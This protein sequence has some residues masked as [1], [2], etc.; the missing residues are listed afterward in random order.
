MATICTTC[1]VPHA[2]CNTCATNVFQLLAHKFNVGACSRKSALRNFTY[3]DDPPPLVTALGDT[4][5]NLWGKGCSRANVGVA[6][7]RACS[8]RTFFRQQSRSNRS[9]CVH[10][11]VPSNA[12]CPSH[13]SLQVKVCS[14]TPPFCVFTNNTTSRLNSLNSLNASLIPIQNTD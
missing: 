9:R 12:C 10:R 1:C 6:D 14:Y 3:S 13:A 5:L 7:A 4:T 11:R 2:V 8:L